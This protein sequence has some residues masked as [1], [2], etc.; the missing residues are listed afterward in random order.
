MDTREAAARLGLAPSTLARYR[1]TGEGP[2]FHRFGGCVRYRED[3]LD[4]WEAER[5]AARRKSR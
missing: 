4:E 2:L 3:H 1:T 5:K